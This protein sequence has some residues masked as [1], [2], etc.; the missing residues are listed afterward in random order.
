FNGHKITVP[1]GSAIGDVLQQY[2]LF[3]CKKLQ[4]FRRS[5]DGEELP[6]FIQFSNSP[7]NITLISGDR[8]NLPQ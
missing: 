6:V 7:Q 2:G 1:V 8:I 3:D 5:P 4:L